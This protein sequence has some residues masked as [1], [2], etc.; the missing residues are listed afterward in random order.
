MQ[1]NAKKIIFIA[2]LIIGCII[3]SFISTNNKE[4]SLPMGSMLQ[5]AQNA[6]ASKSA[7]Q[8]TVR[9]QLSGAILE[10]GV[11]DLPA[12]C[13]VEEAITAAGG[14]T[15]N[16]DSERV[17]LVRKVRDGMQIR[18]PVKKAA[19]KNSKQTKTAQAI[20]DLSESTSRKSGSNKAGS[21][22]NSSLLPRVRINSASV[23]E[24]Q[25]LPGIGPALAQRIIE[26]RSGGR[27]N[28]ADDLLRVPGIGKTKLAKLRDYVEVD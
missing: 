17:N 5:S 3:T 20:A 26:T 15:E 19:R 27:F 22:K 11:Y 23:S 18:V 2:V 12:N 9:V 24:L 1:A 14:L 21:G 25:Q 13:R 28:S 7:Q 16:A 10:P 6:G 4:K 8:K